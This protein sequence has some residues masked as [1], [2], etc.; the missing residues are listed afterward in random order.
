MQ[1]AG[2]AIVE[3]DC[4]RFSTTAGGDTGQC[5]IG[6]GRALW[7]DGIRGC[8]MPLESFE[9]IYGLYPGHLSQQNNTGWDGRRGL[10]KRPGSPLLVETK[11]G[12]VLRLRTT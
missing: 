12:T 2:R 5:G 8:R 9:G 4:G 1:E 10:T 7:S 6:S 3:G 11:T